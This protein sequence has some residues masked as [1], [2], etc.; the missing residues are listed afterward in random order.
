MCERVRW[1]RDGLIGMSRR[2]RQA[3]ARDGY[4]L[5]YPVWTPDSEDR[6]D[7]PLVV[8]INAGRVM[9]LMILANIYGGDIIETPVHGLS[10]IATFWGVI[11]LL[12]LIAGRPRLRSVIV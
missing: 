9:G 3:M 10:G 1:Q 5:T 7:A 11:I 4:R 2:M 6:A 12:Y 8:L